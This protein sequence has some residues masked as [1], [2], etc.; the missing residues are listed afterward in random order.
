M[1][2]HVDSSSKDKLSS[3][4]KS[5]TKFNHTNF[6]RNLR[7]KGLPESKTVNSVIPNEQ[8]DDKLLNSFVRTSR[9]TGNQRAG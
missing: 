3:I 9:N 4:S 2:Q 7:Q 8:H 5:I 6:D 1:S